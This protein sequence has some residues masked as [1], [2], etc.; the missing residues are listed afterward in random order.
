MII[1]LIDDVL[2]DKKP[3]ISK[4]SNKVDFLL[5]L[6]KNIDD[7]NVIKDLIIHSNIDEKSKKFLFEKFNIPLPKNIITS[8][9]LKVQKNKSFKKLSHLSDQKDISVLKNSNLSKPL[10]SVFQFKA[11]NFSQKKVLNSKITELLK[12]IKNDKDLE[13]KVEKLPLTIQYE[14]VR[15]IKNIIISKVK[16]DNQLNVLV[17]VNEFKRVKN[18]KDLLNLTKKLGLN[19][20][21]I[22]L[23]QENVKSNESNK[24]ISLDK[25]NKSIKNFKDKPIESMKIN[26]RNQIEN[27][28]I[29]NQD[30]SKSDK[31]SDKLF[32]VQK[33][34]NNKEKVH[35]VN[36]N[37]LLNKDKKTENNKNDNSSLI[38]IN[39]QSEFKHKVIE[40]KQSIKHFVTSLKEAVENYKPPITKISLEL[41]PKEL[42]KVEV[43]IKQQGDNLNVQIN[44]QNQTTINFLT[45]QQQELKNSLVNMGFTNINMNFNSNN[46]NQRQNQHQKNQYTNSYND[47][48]EELIIDFTYKYA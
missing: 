42:G 14:V 6:L 31:L 26:I 36:L 9:N 33:L 30:L 38:G 5:E 22:V 25:V 43:V 17:N 35:E 2:I 40:A 3:N 20:T 15:E 24:F 29:K 47:E 18:I 39:L 37:I 41:H 8:L 12:D 21:K 1:P 48:D 27:I 28:K 13:K 10:K 16:N 32:N 4:A 46:Q 23:K 34:S 44:T 11:N 7:K 19:I 45:S